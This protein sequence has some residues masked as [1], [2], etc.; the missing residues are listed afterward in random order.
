MKQRTIRDLLA[1]Q[2]LFSDLPESDFD[3]LAGCGKNTH[4]RAG[5]T[6]LRPG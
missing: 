2:P 1:E 4:F 5:E 3:R 6:G